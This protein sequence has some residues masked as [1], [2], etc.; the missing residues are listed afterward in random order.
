MGSY[1]ELLVWKE[2][3]TL[4]DLVY[5]IVSFFPREEVYCLSSQIRRA[6]ISVGSNIAEGAG[7][8]SQRDFIHFLYI[9]RGSAYEVETQAIYADDLHYLT[10]IQSDELHHQIAKVIYLLNK[11]IHAMENNTSYSTREDVVPYGYSTNQPEK[12][13]KPEQPEKPVM[14]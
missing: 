2:A 9:A 13:E 1:K 10:A 11:L 12:L 8:R 14:R 7:R 5:E 4:K 6:A 3:R